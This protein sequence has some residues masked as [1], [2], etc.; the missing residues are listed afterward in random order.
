MEDRYRLKN[1]NLGKC[2]E[3]YQRLFIRQ[4]GKVHPC[5]SFFGGENTVGDI[6]K[7]SIQEIWDSLRIKNFRNSVKKDYKFFI[8]NKCKKSMCY[9][10]K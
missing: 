3:P 10:K 1:I 6:Y 8:C 2:Y 4:D 7:N 5:C 9:E